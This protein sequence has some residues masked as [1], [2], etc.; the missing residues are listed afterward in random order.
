MPR[1]ALFDPSAPPR[2]DALRRA[3]RNCA[4]GASA[5]DLL[6]LEAWEAAPRADVGVT[7]RVHQI[8]RANPALAAEIRAELGGA[9]R[10]RVAFAF[11][12]RFD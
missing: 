4:D 9:G 7:L 11:S 8:R 3:L 10:G 12:A 2:T 6:F 1:I 5:A